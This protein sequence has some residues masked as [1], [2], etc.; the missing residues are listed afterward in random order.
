MAHHRSI[1]GN[2]GCIVGDKFFLYKQ[3]LLTYYGSRETG[4]TVAWEPKGWGSEGDLTEQQF[5]QYASDVCL[6]LSKL[7]GPASLD[8]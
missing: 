8:S 5:Q 7:I 1:K 2:L 4:N 6:L 3:V